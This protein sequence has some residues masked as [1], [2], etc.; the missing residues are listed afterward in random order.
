MIEDHALEV[1]FEVHDDIP[2]GGPGDFASTQRAFLMLPNLSKNPTILDIGCGPGMQTLHLAD[3][4]DG[5]I[6]AVDNHQPFL[7]SLKEKVARRGLADRISVVHGDMFDLDFPP[8][9]FDVLW[10]E[11]SIYIMGF[12]NALGAW[13]SLLKNPGYLAAS[14]ISWLKPDPPEKLRS[15][16]AEQYP[17]MRDIEANLSAIRRSGYTPVGHF[18]L[19]ESDWWHHYYTPI[20]KKIQ[21]LRTKYRD[22]AEAQ[23][24][25]D[26]EE[27]EIE[28]YETYS[29]YYGYV[30][31]VMTTERGMSV[32]R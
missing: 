12:E 13:K 22:D 18:T 32:D 28:L 9:I 20:Q 6:I 15:F 19:P 14:E 25:L 5:T 16:W 1:F 30:F 24:V 3:L 17:G 2:R 21:A 23:L 27:K 4:T 26:M 11:G 31:Y 8:G 7:K 10:A 29:N